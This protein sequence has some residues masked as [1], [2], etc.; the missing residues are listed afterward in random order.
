MAQNEQGEPVGTWLASG[1]ME[2]AHRVRSWLAP[3]LL[4][5]VTRSG[6]PKSGAQAK[7]R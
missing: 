3:K 7:P 5:G 6:R 2:L 1:F 4:R